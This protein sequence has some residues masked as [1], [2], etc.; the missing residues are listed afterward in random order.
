M[1]KTVR[2]AVIGDFNPEFHTHHATNAGLRH[3]A[4]ALNLAIEVEWVP[5]PSLAEPGAVEVLRPYDGLWLAPGS[6]YQS[7]AGAIEA[8][9]FARERDRPFVST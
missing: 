2:I 3:A 7:E 4:D 8:V 5:T 6:P 1:G 9:R